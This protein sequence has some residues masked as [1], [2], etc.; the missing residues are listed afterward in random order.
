MFASTL[1]IAHQLRNH[2][3]IDPY[4]GIKG[5]ADDLHGV[6]TILDNGISTGSI[7]F[8]VDNRVHITKPRGTTHGEWSVLQRVMFDIGEKEKYEEQLRKWQKRGE[9]EGNSILKPREPIKE[10]IYVYCGDQR[11]Y[12]LP[13]VKMHGIY[14]FVK[15]DTPPKEWT[16]PEDECVFIVR[17]RFKGSYRL[18]DHDVPRTWDDART[19]FTNILGVLSQE[20]NVPHAYNAT[21]VSNWYY[22]LAILLGIAL[23][24]KF[25]QGFYKPAIGCWLIDLGVSYLT[26]DIIVSGIHTLSFILYIFAVPMLRSRILIPYLNRKKQEGLISFYN[27]YRSAEAH[28]TQAYRILQYRYYLK[29]DKRLGHVV[30]IAA[31]VGFVTICLYSTAHYHN[32]TLWSEA[33]QT[34]EEKVEKKRQEQEV[35]ERKRREQQNAETRKKNA[36]RETRKTKTTSSSTKSSGTKTPSI[37]TA[38]PN[39]PPNFYPSDALPETPS[40]Q[41]KHTRIPVK[42]TTLTQEQKANIQRLK[43]ERDKAFNANDKARYAELTGEI[44]RAGDTETQYNVA[45]CYEAKNQFLA[46]IYWYQ[47]SAATGHGLSLQSLAMIYEERKSMRNYTLARYYYEKAAEADIAYSHYRLGHYYENGI[48]GEKDLKKALEH[49]YVAAAADLQP[50]KEAYK[51]LSGKQSGDYLQKIPTSIEY[52]EPAVMPPTATP[53]PAAKQTSTQSTAQKSAETGSSTSSNTMKPLRTIDINDSELTLPIKFRKASASN[54]E[55]ETNFLLG[56]EYLKTKN[57]D[58][59]F[60]ALYSAA[61]DGHMNAQYELGKLYMDGAPGFKVDNRIALYWLRKAAE[62]QH[63]MALTRAAYI[64]LNDKKYKNDIAAFQCASKAASLNEISAYYYL[65]NC[66]EYGIGT[67]INL[68]SAARYYKKAYDKGISAAKETLNRVLMKAQGRN[69]TITDKDL[70]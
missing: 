68:L 62:Q 4:G 49:Y 67:P 23:F 5:I 60:K 17:K 59:A 34:Y 31:V 10:L 33:K 44:A 14:G 25:S 48:A 21:K 41:V 2:S 26:A 66:Y 51:R 13:I 38:N 1:N 8:T 54:S 46:A 9:D 39:T 15:F 57:Y 61:Y 22:L 35:A 70:L 7:E 56:K 50:A 47:M 40:S 43:V 36:E 11:F 30:P 55:S 63:A 29:T 6:Y 27:R 20:K 52:R 12:L 32:S 24:C 65:G 45:T 69:I 58:E 64:Y 18:Y 3:L 37:P 28:L 42:K 19:L 53:K 16:S